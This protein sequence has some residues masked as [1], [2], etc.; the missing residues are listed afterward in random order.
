[1]KDRE[2]LPYWKLLASVLLVSVIG[3]YARG[4]DLTAF[5][6]I[7]EA[8][9]YVGE[10]SKD[11]VVQIRSEKSIG[12]LTP[13]IWYVVLYEPTA[14]LK[15]VE[16]KFEAGK[17]TKVTR[18]FRLF[19]PVYGGDKQLDREKLKIDYDAAIKTALQESLLKNLKIT[20]SQLKLEQSNDTALGVG[21]TGQGLWKV[22]LWAA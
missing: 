1:M 12:T 15:A 9:R 10:Q 2:T 4:G 20:A 7:K 18:P 11:K 14:A 6:L 5:E 3:P 19:E 8:N 21:A 13:N 17:M 16:V 22:K